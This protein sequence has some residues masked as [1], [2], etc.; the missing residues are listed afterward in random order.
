MM[1]MVVVVV[2]VLM[3]TPTPTPPQHAVW[4]CCGAA[5]VLTRGVGHWWS[6]GRWRGVH[7]VVPRKAGRQ[8]HRCRGLGPGGFLRGGS[9]GCSDEGRALGRTSE[10]ITDRPLMHRRKRD[11]GM[12]AHVW[13]LSSRIRAHA[14]QWLCAHARRVVCLS[15][16]L[17]RGGDREG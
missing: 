13:L 7:G 11:S 14:W 10:G 6:T 5:A 17:E 8:L 12:H 2:T 3:P 16:C 15:G 4:G 1:M 9:R